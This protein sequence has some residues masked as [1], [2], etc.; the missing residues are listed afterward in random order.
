M[1]GDRLTRRRG[2]TPLADFVGGC[3]APVLRKQGFGESDI[4]LHWPEI[5]GERLAECCEP[6]KLQ[7]PP[8]PPAPTPEAEARPATL[9]VRVEGAFA[10][11]LQHLSSVVIERVN[12]HLG[13][14]CVGRLLL[15][16]GPLQHPGRKPK[17]PPPDA[18]SVAQAQAATSGIDDD[19]LR[20]ALARLGARVLSE[21][22][23][24]P[25]RKTPR[26]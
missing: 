7:W 21:H 22:R 23:A 6:V 3:I 10:L 5:V 19:A 11:E 2:A 26:R 24:R 15:K 12:A 25:G 20:D 9:V 13:W 17:P 4:I 16:Q 1:A 8:A 14:R 18:A